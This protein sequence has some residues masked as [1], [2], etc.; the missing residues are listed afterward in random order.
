MNETAL[1]AE[2]WIEARG[3]GA[4]AIDNKAWIEVQGIGEEPVE[5]EV[6]AE[7]EAEVAGTTDAKRLE[8]GLR[9][10]STMSIRGL[11]Q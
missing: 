11:R 6:E 3:I 9:T 10:I 4:D 5:A 2:V 7:A 8:V 1:E